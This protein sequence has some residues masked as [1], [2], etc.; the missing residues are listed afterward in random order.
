[1]KHNKN[2]SSFIH[3][4]LFISLLCLLSICCGRLDYESTGESAPEEILI[5]AA[6]SLT[7]VVREIAM[8]F[9]GQAP[10]LKV[11]I[12]T[13][14]S[15]QLAKQIEYGA[16]ADIF[17]SA[18]IKWMDYLDEKGLIIS[19]A[20]IE[21]LSNKLVIIG[22]ANSRSFLHS[23]QDL[24]TNKVNY[25]AIADYNSVPAGI[26]ASE[27]LKKLGIWQQ[28]FPKLVLGSDVRIAM[29]YVERGEAE[30]GIVYATDAMV[31]KR[32]ETLFPLPDESQPKIIYSFALIKGSPNARG[33]EAFFDYLKDSCAREIF[34]KH[35]FIWLMESG[36]R[37]T[38]NR[39][40][41]HR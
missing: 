10:G 13:G 34:K 17:L 40:S 6:A 15:A 4:L 9:K 32:V 38:D 3:Y 27:A 28:L 1:M 41:E 22:R 21:S 19:T 29:A 35:G 39:H 8:N 14:S 5:F 25:I 31:S 26:Y 16:P 37:Q 18:D 36:D 23:I 12:S 20:R 2:R 30:C 24:G 7:D 33:A 11:N